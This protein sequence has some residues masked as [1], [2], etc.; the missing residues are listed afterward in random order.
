MLALGMGA[1]S[2][3][4]AHANYTVTRSPG[5]ELCT[6]FSLSNTEG[7]L[8]NP[9]DTNLVWVVTVDG[10]MRTS[11]IDMMLG[12]SMAPG[13][14][15]YEHLF[16]YYNTFGQSNFGVWISAQNVSCA[17]LVAGGAREGCS[18]GLH[19]CDTILL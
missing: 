4:H 18:E 11:F 13:T 7:T 2:P 10:F 6:G 19:Y 8:C 5:T 3:G 15:A 1:T 17:G 9:D 14:E 16:G 12:T